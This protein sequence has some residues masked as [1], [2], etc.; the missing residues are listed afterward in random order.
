MTA[1]T[2]AERKRDQRARDR[3]P[4]GRYEKTYR[5]TKEEHKELAERLQELRREN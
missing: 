5:A 3:L 4:G 1:K 2:S